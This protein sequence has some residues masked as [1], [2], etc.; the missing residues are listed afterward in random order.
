M[1]YT[2]H[3]EF[4]NLCKVNAQGDFLY[5]F[6]LDLERENTIFGYPN[7]ASSWLI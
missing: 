7:L 3:Y 1:F 2:K 4:L 6:Q 5:I